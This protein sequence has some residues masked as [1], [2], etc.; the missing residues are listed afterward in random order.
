MESRLLWREGGE[1]GYFL[2]YLLDE[3]PFYNFLERSNVEKQGPIK[4]GRGTGS[5]GQV[6][7]SQQD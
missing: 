3:E 2:T 6:G 5:E 1:Y 4:L 7:G